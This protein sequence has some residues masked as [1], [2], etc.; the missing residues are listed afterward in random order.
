MTR[1]ESLQITVTSQELQMQAILSQSAAEKSSFAHEKEHLQLLFDKQ[2]QLCVGLTEQV[3]ALTANCERLQSQID[4]ISVKEHLK[5]EQFIKDIQTK[6]AV[7]A[8]EQQQRAEAVS[9]AQ[10]LEAACKNAEAKLAALES[11][12]FEQRQKIELLTEELQAALLQVSKHEQNAAFNEV[13]DVVAVQRSTSAFAFILF[14]SLN[15]MLQFDLQD[16]FLQRRARGCQTVA[17]HDLDRC[18]FQS[19]MAA[20]SGAL[21]QLRGDWNQILIQFARDMEVDRLQACA[22]YLA[23]LSLLL[24]PGPARLCRFPICATVSQRRTWSWSALLRMRSG[25]QPSASKRFKIR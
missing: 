2:Q 19:S 21:Q 16:R 7:V 20:A 17:Q 1:C 12:N 8:L 11:V 10:A 24:T 5:T 15:F 23:A 18:A 14:L 3:V 4:D 25:V 13:F 22:L 6:D 9:R